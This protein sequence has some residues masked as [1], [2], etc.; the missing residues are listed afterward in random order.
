TGVDIGGPVGC[1]DCPTTGHTCGRPDRTPPEGHVTAPL[2]LPLPV[3]SDLLDAVEDRELPLLAWGVTTGALAHAE[4]IDLI[5]DRID[6]GSVVAANAQ[7][8][9]QVLLDQ[10]LLFRLPGTSPP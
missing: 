3:L 2:S 9:L 5:D 1:R 8:V 10:S 4:I 7:S 6:N